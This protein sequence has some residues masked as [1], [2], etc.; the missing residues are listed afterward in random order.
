MASML[1][2]DADVLGGIISGNKPEEQGLIRQLAAKGDGLLQEPGRALLAVLFSFAQFQ[3]GKVSFAADIGKHGRIA[4]AAFVGPGHAF[5][6]G[7]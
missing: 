7:L 2:E 1:Q 5:L 6:A 4:V 3:V